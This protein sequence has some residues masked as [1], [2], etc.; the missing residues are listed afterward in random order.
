MGKLYTAEIIATGG[1]DGYIKSM[2]AMLDWAMRKPRELDGQGGGY[3]PEQLFAAAWGSSYLSTL[4][5]VAAKEGVDVSE[6]EVTV[7]VT[8]NKD[9][10]EFALSAELDVHIP[11]IHIEE[12]QHLA[13]KADHAC[14][15]SKAVKG[16]IDATVIAL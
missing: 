12:A 7:R 4:E 6:A 10:D 13:E 15:Y 3:N 1:R 8:F 5:L 16:N 11:G 9:G 2:D 14:P